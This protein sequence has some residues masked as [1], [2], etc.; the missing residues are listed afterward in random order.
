MKNFFRMFGIIA[1]VAVIS[2]SMATCEAEIEGEGNDGGGGGGGGIKPTITIKNN[3]GYYIGGIFFK[4]STEAQSWGDNYWGYLMMSDGESRDF[5]LT[6]PLSVCKVYDILFSSGEYDF[7][8][9]GFTISNKMTITFTVSD[10]ND[11]SSLPK[12][13]IQNRTGKNFDSINIVPSALNPSDPSDWGKN[14]GGVLNNRDKSDINILVSPDKYTVFDIQARS[15]NPTNTY[16][17]TNVTISNG[18]TLLFTGADRDNAT[19]E[20]PVIVIQNNTGYSTGIFIRQSGTDDWGNDLWGY[21]MLSNNE[22]RTFSVSHNQIDI[23]LNGSGFN[24]IK[25]NVAVTD[26]KVV[27]FT[28]SDKAD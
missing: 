2:F 9:Y 18:M 4:P 13:T 15:S 20:A 21:L 26:G 25:M 17:K 24:F 12:I 7:R 3:T 22:L 27:T 10:L 5:T 8:K 14:F 19:I 23:K 28:T 16:T 1:L 11:G 6:Q